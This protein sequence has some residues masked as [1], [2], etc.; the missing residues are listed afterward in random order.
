MKIENHLKDKLFNII[1][2][3]KIFIFLFM[4]SLLFLSMDTT[5]AINLNYDQSNVIYDYKIATLGMSNENIVVGSLNNVNI[6]NQTGDIKYELR[7]LTRPIYILIEN[8]MENITLDI[9]YVNDDAVAIGEINNKIAISQELTMEETGTYYFKFEPSY[10]GENFD[11]I[12]DF[13]SSY[14]GNLH[15]KEEQ[16]KEFNS[17]I[18]GFIDSFEEIVK[19][20]VTL[21][22]LLFYTIIFLFTLS[23]IIGLFGGSFWIL[24]Q[25][26]K[27]REGEN[28]VFK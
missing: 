6:G 27:I 16:A 24:K 26:K 1:N 3:K 15:L 5:N 22:R 9:T 17:L 14:V 20:N 25:A 12:I 4:F 10:D 23:F 11:F 2:M 7:G 28:G 8:G 21:W 13:P 19:I 18:S